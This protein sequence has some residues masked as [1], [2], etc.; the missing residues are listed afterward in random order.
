M[1]WRTQLNAYLLTNGVSLFSVIDLNKLNILIKGKQ[2]MDTV[3]ISALISST[4]AIVGVFTSIIIARWQSKLQTKELNLKALELNSSLKKLEA[5]YEALRQE[6][7]TEILKMRLETYPK[8][9][10]I[11]LKYG[12][13]WKY[14]GKLQ[15]NTWVKEFLIELRECNA[16]IGI[17]FSQ[18]LY[19]K[20]FEYYCALVEIEFKFSKGKHV[21]PEELDSLDMIFLG[22][23]NRPGL[24]TILKDDLGSYRSIALQRREVDNYEG[25]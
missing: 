14:E 25:I 17:Y 16:Q 22:N 6:Q 8:L 19:E 18:A 11:L 9:W 3:I 12:H 2:F 15:D 10:K 13:Y 24:A 1:V 5:D 21:L 20:Y 4:V 23:G 7:F